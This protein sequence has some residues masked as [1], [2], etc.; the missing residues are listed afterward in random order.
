MTTQNFEGL[1]CPLPLNHNKT[2]VIGHGSGGRMTHDLIRDIFQSAFGNP[3]LNSGNDFA[4]LHLPDMAALRGSLSVSTDGHIVKPIIFPGGDIGR[5]AVSGT[6]N[7]ISMSGGEPLFLTVSFILEEGLP[8]ETLGIIATS[9]QKTAL[10]AGIQ[11]VAGD[12]KVVEK[13]KADKIFLST[14]GI[15]WIPEGRSIGGAHAQDGDV[16]ILSGTIGD[17]GMAVLAAR[18]ELNFSAAIESDVAPL[19]KL[20]KVI[21]ECAPHVHVLRD[22]TRGGL[23]TTLNEIAVQSQMIITLEEV[24]IPVKPKVKAACEMLGFD[25]LYVANEGKV[26]IILPVKE[27][28]AALKCLHQH[29]LGKDAALIGRIEKGS[30]AR[31]LLKTVIGGTRIVDMLSGEMLPRI[32]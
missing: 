19:N 15:G 24:A 22:P 16:V 28:G 20:I 12:T 18:G 4:N 3:V 13:G 8:V 29:P 5:L 1:I 31:V 17:H 30:A 11:I 9:I 27:A 2:I 26:V 6:V 14:T 25:P 10:E 23:A 21:L 32:C 7:D